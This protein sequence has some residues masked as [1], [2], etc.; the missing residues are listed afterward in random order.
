MDPHKRSAT[1]EVI[2]ERERVQRTGRFSLDRRGFADLL[3]AGKTFPDRVWAVEGCNGAGRPVAQRLV[4]AGELVLDVPAKLSARARVFDGGNGRKSDP[5]D[6]HHVAVAALRAKDL[7]P[8]TADDDLVAIRLLVDRRDELGSARTATVNRLHR[9]LAELIPAGAGKDLSAAQ[10]KAL[11][12][13]VRPADVAGKTRK[14]LAADLLT[15]LAVIDKRIKTA[16]AELQSLVLARGSTLMELLGIG[17]SGAARLLG[18]VGDVTRFTNRD[19]FASWNGTAPLDASSGDH[20]RHRLSRAGNR[21]IN[22]VLHMMAISQLRSPASEGRAY[23]DRK[24]AEG[25]TAME[26]RRCLKRRLSDIVY[27]RMLDDLTLTAAP[28][29]DP[30]GHLGATPDSCA[31]DSHPSV[32]TSEQPLPGPATTNPRT[33]PSATA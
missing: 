22:R 29:T 10:A 16:S 30:G 31:A 25:K 3:A 5:I 1:I 8:V 4:A 23:Y 14:R 24:R 6:A 33:A 28:R 13:S 9:L 18:D 26:A 15:D 32:G 20:H 2:D 17:P 27:R 19:R 12:A 7:R 21:R 11:L